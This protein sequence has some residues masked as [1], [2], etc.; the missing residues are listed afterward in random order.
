M[1]E[2]V[3]T[4]LPS[5]PSF[6]QGAE[7]CGN[8]K[9][10]QPHSVD[11]R[12]WV[13]PCR[14]QPQRGLFPPTAPICDHFAPK[15][16]AAAALP[17]EAVARVRPLKSFAPVVVKRRPD[18]GLPLLQTPPDAPPAE[19]PLETAPAPAGPRASLNLRV[20][21]SPRAY[22][23]A[24]ADAGLQVDLGGE[25][26]MTR[27]ELMDIFREAA[28]DMHVPL[29]QKWEG[30]T[31]QLVPGKGELQGKELPID[32]FFHKVVMV[33][34]RLRTLEQKINAHPKLSD[35]EKVDMQQYITRVYG[36]LTSF[37]VLF[38]DRADQFTGAKSDD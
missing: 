1:S 19:G 18:A 27:D 10:W 38:R 32:T 7:V 31:L 4:E 22:R 16:S 13:G 17:E 34:D 25:L 33:R 23:S 30:G 35:A 9:L 5:I 26:N 37:N 8:C 36:S 6:P 11:A 2:G 29:A 14:L 3:P 12:G 21:S 28:G 24:R 15:G 20:E